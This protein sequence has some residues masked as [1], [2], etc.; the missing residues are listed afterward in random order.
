MAHPFELALA[1]GRSSCPAGGP[2]EDDYERFDLCVACTAGVVRDLKERAN[3]SYQD[4]MWLAGRIKERAA[5][6]QK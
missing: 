2:S 6:R 5:N 1:V 4:A 3:L